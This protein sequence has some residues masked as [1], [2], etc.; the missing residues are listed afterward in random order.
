MTYSQDTGIVQRSLTR[1]ATLHTTFPSTREA[2]FAHALL[3][4]V[5]QGEPEQ[6]TAAVFDF[7]QVSKLDNWKT[8]ILLKIKR[9]L[10][11]QDGD[12]T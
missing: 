2:K 11:A 3:E 10:E 8:A 12:F 7:D 9:N 6:Y 4:A 5:K 1:Y